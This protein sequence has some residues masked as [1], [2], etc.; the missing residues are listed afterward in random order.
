M[1]NQTT[2]KDNVPLWLNK[3]PKSTRINKN[4]TIIKK[5]KWTTKGLKGAMDAVERGVTS[6]KK[7]DF[8]ILL[9]TLLLDTSTTKPNLVN[10]AH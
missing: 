4:A 3:S 2:N 5:N 1:L 10:K 9:L 8:E 6:L 7:I